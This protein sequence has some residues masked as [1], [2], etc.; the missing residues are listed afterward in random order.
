MPPG[1]SDHESMVTRLACNHFIA[2]EK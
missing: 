1:S 2:F